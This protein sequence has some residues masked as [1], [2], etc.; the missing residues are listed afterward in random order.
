MYYE[1]YV[2]VLFV[3][4]LWINGMLLF[5]TALA[6]GTDLKASR[7]LTAACFGSLGAC[8][9]TAASEKLSG[10]HYFSG[11]FALAV[12]MVFIAFSGKGHI[13][14]KVLF[15]YLEGF[16]LNGL[17]TYFSQFQSPDGVWFVIFGSISVLFLAVSGTA[18]RRLKRRETLTCTVILRCGDCRLPAKA[19]Y[20]SGNGLRDPVNGQPVSILDGEFLNRLLK[21]SGRENIPRLIPYRTISGSGI[22]EAYYLDEMELPDKKGGRIVR[23]PLIARMPKGSGQ[24]QLI[25]HRDLLSS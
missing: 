12:G 13:W 23:K 20:D 6:D 14:R 7:I 8:A 22:L 4:N 21:G 18:I 10:I 25:L 15:L 24:Y 2:D 19:L 9:L 17:F 11:T 3:K 5:L 16:V 1:V